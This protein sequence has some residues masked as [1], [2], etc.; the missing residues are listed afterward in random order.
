MKRISHILILFAVLLATGC[1]HNNGDIGHL[2]G[3]WKVTEAT[4]N[5]RP[6]DFDGNTLFFAFQNNVVGVHATRADHPYVDNWHYGKFYYIEETIDYKKCE[7]L[8]LDYSAAADFFPSFIPLD[9]APN[10]MRVLSQSPGWMRWSMVRNS[11]TYVFTLQ[12]WN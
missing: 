11:C 5:D 3:T 2:F 10:K 4:I 1:T 9:N 8:V 7:T 12:K 6:Y